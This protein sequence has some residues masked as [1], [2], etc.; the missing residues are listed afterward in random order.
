MPVVLPEEAFER[1]ID[2]TL[3][4]SAAIGAMLARAE[5]EFAHYPVSTRLNA[6]REDDERLAA[7]LQ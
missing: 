6:A 2:P 7:P 3:H 5:T 4:D 1:W